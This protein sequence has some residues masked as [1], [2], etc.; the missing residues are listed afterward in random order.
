MKKYLLLFLSFSYLEGKIDTKKALDYDTWLQTFGEVINLFENFYYK[1]ID[2][3]NSMPLAIKAFAEQDPHTTYLNE[4]ACA[5]L[6]EKMSGE[7]CGI[8]VALPG[9]NKKNE[10]F[11]PIIEIIPGGPAE[12]AGLKAGDKIIQ[13]DNDII[14]GLELEEIMPKLRGEKGT[15]VAIKI[16]RAPLQDP[17]TIEV[18]RDIVKEEIVLAYFF[19][20][21]KVYYLLLSI[22]GEKSDTLVKKIIEK[23]IHKNARGLIIDLRNNTGGLFDSALEIAAL[24][25]PKGS[26]VVSIKK[27]DGSL[28]SEW[29]TKHTPMTLPSTM[30]IFIVVNNYTASSSE[31]LSGVLQSYAHQ[32]NQ[33]NVFVIGEETFGKGSIQEVIP[34]GNKGA[35]KLTTGLYYLPDGKCIQGKG[36][37]PDFV[38]E[39]RTPPTETMQ[40]LSKSYG[41]ESALHGHI[42]QDDRTSNTKTDTSKQNSEKKNLEEMPWKERREEI[43]SNDY[44][45]Q[46]TL[47]LIN[48]F[49][50]GRTHYEKETK[51]HVKMIDFIKKQHVIDV[52]IKLEEVKLN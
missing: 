20:E 8:G 9:E 40:W 15:K 27:R 45:I 6:N 51:N 41:K 49:H 43:L 38:I 50:A 32:K 30:P 4:K 31:I 10:E 22:F 34:V 7:F 35:V 44:H 47:N 29:K 28:A 21:H 11:L 12:K 42:K 37:I 13:I 1:E 19:Q 48:L 33:L 14:K 36:I 23:A 5:E 46:N 39:Q 17:L 26:P 16:M 2:P 52:P 18:M 25:L 24:F 3:I